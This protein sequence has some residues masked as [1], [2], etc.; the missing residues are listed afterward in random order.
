MAPAHTLRRFAAFALDSFV[1][2]F[3]YV[4]VWLQLWASY[5]EEGVPSVEIG[6]VG[7]SLLLQLF[8]KWLF[9]YFMQGTPGKLLMGLRVISRSNPEAGLGLF[10]SFL[11]VLTDSLSLFFGQSL[12]ALALI[13]LDRTHVSDW[14]AETQVVQLKPRNYPPRRHWV[15]AI[16]VVVVSFLSQFRQ[17]YSLVQ[18]TQLSGG[19]VI[20]DSDLDLEVEDEE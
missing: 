11:R 17:I 13:R 20:L 19:H 4:P 1:I 2:S 5:M 14:V 15:V 12:R 6:W 18:N 7:A 8:Y 3:C 9:L 10:Q 16:L